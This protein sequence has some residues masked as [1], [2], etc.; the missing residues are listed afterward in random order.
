M[1]KFSCS[2]QE[3]RMM[4]MIRPAKSPRLS[5]GGYGGGRG[6]YGGARGGFGGG[7]GPRGGL[8][9]YQG[10]SPRFGK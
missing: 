8:G 2:G 6:G 10:A 7:S 5:Y 1:K 9:G 4:G 3:P